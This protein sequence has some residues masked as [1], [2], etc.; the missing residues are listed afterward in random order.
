MPRQNYIIES[1]AAGEISPRMW[2][3]ISATGYQQGLAECVNMIP[4]TRGPCISRGAL[5]HFYRLTGYSN[6]N[7]YDMRTPSIGEFIIVLVDSKLQV[8]NA[9]TLDTVVAAPDADLVAPYSSGHLAEVHAYLAPQTPDMYFLHKDYPP[10]KLNLTGSTWTFTA[11]TFTAKPASWLVGNYPG[12]MTFFQGRSWWAGT[13]SNPETFWASQ[14]GLYENLTQGSLASDGLQFTLASHGLI[15]WLDG[16][17]NLLIG[18]DEKEFIANAEAGVITP[19]DIQV[20][21]QSAYGAR[22]VKP[23]ALGPETLYVSPDGRKL[24]SMWYSWTESGWVSQDLSEASE[25]ITS[26]KIKD[27]GFARNPDSVAWMVDEGGALIGCSYRRTG[28]EKPIIGWH[29]HEV[30]SSVVKAVAVL[31]HTG[32]SVPFVALHRV[33]DSASEIHV[34]WINQEAPI[35]MDGYVTKVFGSPGTVVTGLG[36]L[37]GLE[38]QVVADGAVRS[39]ATVASSQITLAEPATTVYIGLS[40]APTAKTLPLAIGDEKGGGLHSLKRWNK[41]VV[42][43]YDSAKPLIN[44][45]RPPERSPSTPM[46]T[47]EPARTENVTVPT[48]GWDDAGQITVTQDLP[49]PLTIINVIGEVATEQL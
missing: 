47:A 15:K 42:R 29:R 5:R 39:N 12:C 34:E 48:L 16:A 45:V 11:V 14:S 13:P 43:V 38:V 10:Y 23:A 26:G 46:G 1:F 18:T 30:S 37:E 22:N 25:H 24:R 9:A 44:G 49:L 32:D 36:H 35:S 31:E 40:L 2:G 21:Q 3:R 4:D 28:S 27:V 6:A 41:A 17:K 8:L 20:E 19:S 33:I 7:I